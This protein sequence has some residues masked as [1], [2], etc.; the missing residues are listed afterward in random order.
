MRFL[1]LMDQG[2]GGGESPTAVLQRVE[3]KVG[4]YKDENARL[5]TLAKEQGEQLTVQEKLIKQH[6]ETIKT[7][8]EAFEELEVKLNKTR[9]GNDSIDELQNALPDDLRKMIPVVKTMEE[10]DA[11]MVGS[12]LHVRSGAQ[13][14]L[15]KG[16]PVKYV[17][18]GGWF[19][20]KIKAQ[21]AIK[22]GDIDDARKWNERADKLCEAM[23]GVDAK[24]KASLQEDVDSEGG[25][26]V[27]SITEPVIGALLKEFSVA[28]AA[29]PTIIQMRSK[30]HQLPTRDSDF[31]V[32]WLNEEGTITDS[33]PSVPF[34]EG[35]LIAKK[36]AGLVTASIELIQDSIINL[37]DVI[38]T[39]LIQQIGRAEDTQFLEGDG[40]TFEGLFS[41]AGTNSVA[42]GS[43][44]I[45][46]PNFIKL[47][48]A[49]EHASTLDGGVV[50]C[51]PWIVRDLL[52]ST[53]PEGS[54]TGV[55]PWFNMLF[56]ATQGIMQSNI[57][58]IPIFKTSV[59]SRVRS[60]DE[61]TVYH[62]IPRWG[63]IGDRMGTTFVVNPWSETEFK[64]GQI[65]M[66][67][68][69]RVAILI[70]VP[71]YFNKLTAVQVVA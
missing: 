11:V 63:V 21:L 13:V 67:L 6:D 15:A 65:L 17:A 62:G 22:N 60:T 38:M 34:G 49:G 26:F 41:V 58:G 64:K 33:T 18:I 52:T 69:R 51:H 61:T 39:H 8:G 71:A 36:Q 27:P 56:A 10:G 31:T 44:P 59:I 25:F 5:A 37:M 20:A 54:T 45:T 47:V 55:S 23:G 1:L 4:E 2:G 29:G 19:Q 3:K 35:S 32:Q 46:V 42:G 9:F 48:Y 16:D 66:R 43:A 70:W 12:E 28:R 14:R 57:G 50:W 7:Q 24:I 53:T 68:L 30:M 40:T